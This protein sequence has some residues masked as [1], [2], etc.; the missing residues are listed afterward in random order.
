MGVFTQVKEIEELT[1]R[2]ES[3]VRKRFY[4]V[5]RIDA[6]E[7]AESLIDEKGL[8]AV[9]RDIDEAISE[10]DDKIREAADSNVTYDFDN[11]LL[12]TFEPYPENQE[13]DDYLVKEGACAEEPEYFLNKAVQLYAYELWVAGIRNALK[14][15]LKERCEKA[16]LFRR[17]LARI[18]R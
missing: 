13:V 2:L 1:R 11:F 15:V 6:E 16:G 9:C 7:I 14:E 3:L 4:E 10:A 12:A 8:D 18:R 5:A 17:S